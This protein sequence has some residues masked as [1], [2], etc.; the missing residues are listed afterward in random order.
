MT[1]LQQS[2]DKEIMF[3]AIDRSLALIIFDTHGKVLWT[4]KNFAQIFGYETEEL[5]NMHHKQL[6][7]STFSNSQQY[8]NLWNNLRSNKAFYDKVERVSKYGSVLVLDAMYTP[9]INREGEIEAV[10]KI[11]Y[12]ITSRDM[13]LK[14]STA[15]FMSLVE[16]MT[17][18]TDEV[19]NASQT[20]VNNIEELTKE[21]ETVKEKVEQIQSIA[22]TVKEIA[23]Q[24]NLLGLN[25]SIEA[26]RE[27][28]HGRGFSVVAKEIRKLADTSK[29]SAENISNQLNE[30]LNSVTVMMKTV[31]Q[32]TDNINKNSVSIEELENAYNHVAKTAEELANII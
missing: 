19:H 15:Q 9:V 26:A 31:K 11:A 16:E 3:D 13:I 25:A 10:I 32:V 23:A 14:N 7:T 20:V 18:S 27:G 1:L 8:I 24:S 17:A 21:S 30:I 6:C 5:T 12:D 29:N 22:T 4:N 28:D 2:I